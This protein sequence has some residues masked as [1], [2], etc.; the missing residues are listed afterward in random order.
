MRLRALAPALLL[1]FLAMPALAHPPEKK[2]SADAQLAQLDFL[3]GTWRNDWFEATY[4][5]PAGGM[6]LSVN[7][8]FRDGKVSFFEIERFD[9]RD[10]KVTMQPFLNGKQAPVAFPL[11]ALAGKRAHF[12]NAAHD[13]P[14]D[15]VYERVADDRLLIEL[16]GV[17]G[18]QARQL[19]FDLRRAID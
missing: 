15:L 13:F 8:E 17:E 16:T 7:K 4:T 10:G 3:A 12:R 18:G 14:Q 2:M 19:R 5:T 6:V 1:P 11:H 9:V